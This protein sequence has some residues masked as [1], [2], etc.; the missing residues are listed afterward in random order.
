MDKHF[1]PTLR[2]IKH[3]AVPTIAR[4]NGP[5]A[6][7]GL[8]LALACDIVVA[9]ESAFFVAT[10]GPRLGIVPDLGSTWS[11]PQKIGAARAR[12]MAMLGERISAAQAAEWG[13]IYCSIADDQLDAEI[14]RVASV[15]RSTSR[16]AMQRIRSS[17]DSASTRS[18]DDQL[19]LER[20]HQAVLI[21]LNMA[22]GAAAFLEKRDPKF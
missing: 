14:A 1:N 11:L 18:F 10:F 8:G 21:P 22:E 6:G 20:D 13:L 2:A 9:A 3:C 7:G 4:V 5:A 15:L 12:A 17:V 19:E 16:E